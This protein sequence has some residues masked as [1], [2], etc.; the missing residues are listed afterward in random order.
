MQSAHAPQGVCYGLG[1][2][3]QIWGAISIEPILQGRHPLLWAG[4][5]PG[6][7]QWIGSHYWALRVV[8]EAKD[9]PPTPEEF[10]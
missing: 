2:V 1:I 8:H 10:S 9:D 7:A 3:P 4:G 5:V 6:N